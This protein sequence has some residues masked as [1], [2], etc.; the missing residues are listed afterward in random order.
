MLDLAVCLLV[1]TILA[2]GLAGSLFKLGMQD[3]AEGSSS[4]SPG[5]SLHGCGSSAHERGPRQLICNS[6]NRCTLFY[7]GYLETGPVVKVRGLGG[8]G[9]SAPC[10]HLSPPAIVYEPP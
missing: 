6:D 4:K 7:F 10:S 3:S 1:L 9:S 8:G 2:T 5:W